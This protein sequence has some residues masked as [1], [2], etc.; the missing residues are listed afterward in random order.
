MKNKNVG[1]LSLIIIICLTIMG[2]VYYYY[3]STPVVQTIDSTP[4]VPVEAPEPNT[5]S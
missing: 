2:F 3:V 1:L 5:S 4:N